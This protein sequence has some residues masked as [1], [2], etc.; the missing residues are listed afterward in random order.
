MG[1]KMNK[2]NSNMEL[3]RV[4]AMLMIV[5]HHIY[6]H[7][8]NVQ[9]TDIRAD[10]L[11]Y[12]P[13][14]SERLAVLALISPMGQIGNAVFILISGYFMAHKGS[15]ID[16]ARTAKKLLFQLGFAAV[17]IS[18]AS[19][20]TYN[21]VTGHAVTLVDFNS[22]NSMS[23]FVGYY[24]LII[25]F[26]KLFLNRF[27]DKL[28]RKGYAAFLIVLFALISFFWS[29]SVM[30]NLAMGIEIIFT[31]VFLYSLGGFIRK[32]NPFEK[33]R[34]WVLV[35][36]IV[37]INAVIYGNYYVAAVNNIQEFYAQG[38]E[39]FI[40]TI[41]LYSDYQFVPIALGI[42]LFELFRRMK[43]PNSRVI[44]YLGAA[45]FMVYLTHDNEFVYSLWN[46]QDWIAPLHNDMGRFI[47]TYFIWLLGTFGA[48]VLIYTLYV[49]AGKLCGL[50]K[51]LVF[52]KN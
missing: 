18:I 48:G 3:L 7:C 29:R 33:I 39:I 25:L 1:D 44:N 23:W 41:P 22:F 20:A 30:A 14:V 11:F 46:F 40:H 10:G 34:V 47:G 42:V 4:L 35:A 51:P 38:E 12:S 50:C 8:I 45:T 2:R 28:D 43:L 21:N 6:C 26:A 24:F 52:K 27:L 15:D 5:A 9:L 31:G 32:Y 13:M 17:V 36:I 49:L 19:I 16:L 37:V